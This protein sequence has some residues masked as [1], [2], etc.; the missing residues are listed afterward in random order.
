M[1]TDPK[2]PMTRVVICVFASRANFA[3]PKSETYSIRS[4]STKIRIQNRTIEIEL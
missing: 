3:S 2:V 1:N 4:S